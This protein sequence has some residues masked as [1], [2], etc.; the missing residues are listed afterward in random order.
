MSITGSFDMGF[1]QKQAVAVL[2]IISAILGLCAVVLTTSGELKAMML[3][4]ALC[5]A[6]AVSARIFLSNNEKK[7]TEDKDHKED[8]P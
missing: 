5:A 8:Q 6:G 2:Y 3:L 1:N 7:K 4:L